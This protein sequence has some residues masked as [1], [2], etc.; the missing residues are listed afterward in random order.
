MVE[1]I[2]FLQIIL[3]MIIQKQLEIFEGKSIMFTASHNVNEHRFERVS[4]WRDVKNYFNSIEN[5][6]DKS[7]RSLY[8][9]AYDFLLNILKLSFII[10]CCFDNA[11]KFTN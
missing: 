1:R 11:F 2:L 6:E 8:L 10:I 5:R 4:G 9:M 3:L 7:H